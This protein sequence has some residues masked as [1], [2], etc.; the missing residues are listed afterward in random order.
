[1]TPEGVRRLYFADATSDNRL[2][3]DLTD[4]LLALRSDLWPGFAQQVYLVDACANYVG[5]R[6]LSATLPA[7]TLAK[8][9]P[10]AAR[11]QFALLGAKAGEVAVVDG[12]Q[13]T[14]TFSR[15][16]FKLLQADAAWPPD[17]VRLTQQLQAALR[18]T[19]QR[20]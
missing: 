18:R 15:E 16:L 4:L 17:L 6:D 10:V 7:Q 3:L 1:M 9:T 8:G 20:R 12:K 11:Q 19:P 5:P 2:N 14:G 13:M